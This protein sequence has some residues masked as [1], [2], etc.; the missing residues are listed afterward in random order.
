[1]DIRKEYGYDDVV[2][3]PKPSSINSRDDVDISITLENQG[4]NSKVKLDFPLI[5]SPMRGIV[6]GITSKTSDLINR[7]ETTTGVPVCLL[8]TG[9]AY[10]NIIDLYGEVDWD[11]I[12]NN[13]NKYAG[14]GT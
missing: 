9:K 5:A 3:L 7:I 2:I 11:D 10:N 4:G 12:D 6:D 1:M 14:I 13:V 8:N